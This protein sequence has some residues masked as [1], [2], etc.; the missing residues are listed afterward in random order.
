MVNK[1]LTEETFIDDDT[2]TYDITMIP[3]N[4]TSLRSG[5][6]S[7]KNATLEVYEWSEYTQV[8]LLLQ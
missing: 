2:C 3:K 6:A 7:H 8:P 1:P 4:S 5:T